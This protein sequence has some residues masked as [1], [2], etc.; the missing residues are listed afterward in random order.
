[1]KSLFRFLCKNIFLLLFFYNG[2]AQTSSEGI[3]KS[4][5]IFPTN[6]FPECHASSIVQTKDGFLVTWFAGTHEKI[7][8][9]LFMPA[10]IATERGLSPS[11]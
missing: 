11:N 5:F 9:F 8:M 10:D 6:E 4:E 1:M 7:Q 2:Q 3:V